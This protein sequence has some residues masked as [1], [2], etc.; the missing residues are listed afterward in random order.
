M[1]YVLTPMS[2]CARTWLIFLVHVGE[3]F[4]LAREHHLH[5]YFDNAKVRKIRE[6]IKILSVNKVLNAESITMC[7]NITDNSFL[8]ST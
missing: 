3:S 7:Y 2:F 6:Y 5:L 8:M 4:F 1:F